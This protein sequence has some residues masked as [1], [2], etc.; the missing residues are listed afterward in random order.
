MWNDKRKIE[1]IKVKNKNL[2]KLQKIMIG[3]MNG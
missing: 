2:R 1:K 3:K